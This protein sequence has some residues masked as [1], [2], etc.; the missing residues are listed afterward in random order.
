MVRSYIASV[1]KK[2]TVTET[3]GAS[4]SPLW[5]I[6]SFKHLNSPSLLNSCLGEVPQPTFWLLE[7]RLS[8][9]SW[10]ILLFS[11]QTPFRMLYSPCGVLDHCSTVGW[12]LQSFIKKQHSQMCSLTQ[13]LITHWESL[14]AKARMLQ[15]ERKCSVNVPTDLTNVSSMSVNRKIIPSV[16]L[17]FLFFIS[18]QSRNSLCV[19]DG[20]V[21]PRHGLA[22]WLTW[23]LLALSRYHSPSSSVLF[24]VILYYLSS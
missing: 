19:S 3:F 10:V 11:S 22:F 18:L 7:G 4:S 5:S 12:P 13:A 1:K 23:P 14:A 21:W 6:S 15:R 2:W 20:A 16:S 9:V 24:H 17:F 8:P